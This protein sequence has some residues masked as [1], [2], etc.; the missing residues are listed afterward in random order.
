MILPAMVFVVL[1]WWPGAPPAAAAP[2]PVHLKAELL[3][4]AGTL[5]PGGTTWIGVRLIPDRGWHV[6]WTNPGDSG[7]P[8]V[9]SWKLPKGFTVGEVR[10]PRPERIPEGPLVSFGYTG[11]VLLMAPLMMPRDLSAGATVALAASARWL[12]CHEICIPGRAELSLSLVAGPGRAGASAGTFARA[13]G[14]L[15]APS[16]SGWQASAAVDDKAIVLDLVGADVRVPAYFFPLRENLLDNAAAQV[17]RRGKDGARL[18]LP[19]SDQA[20][21][22]SGP[23][24][25][26]LVEGDRAWAL[27]VPVGG[28]RAD[29]KATA[30]GLAETPAFLWALAF[31]F[32]GGMILNLM[33]CVFPILSIK[34]LGFVRESGHHPHEVRIH[35]LLYGTGVVVSF[36]AL[37]GTL[38]VL[39]S[40]GERLGW[41]FQLQSPVV[42]FLL[43][44]TLFLVALN[45]LGVFEAGT[46]VARHAGAVKWGEGR[47]AAFSTGVLATFLATPC[48]APFM[49]TAV[50]YAA[51]QPAAVGLGIFTALGL[52]MAA[53]YVALSFVPGLGRLLP[54][55]GRWMET[56]KQ[57]MAFPLIAT[58]IWMLWVLGLQAGLGAVT[59]SLGCLLALGIAGWLYGRWH[60]G[61][62]RAVAG[63]LIAL[64][65]AAV[66]AWLRHADPSAG[67]R[68]SGVWQPWSPARVE[69]ETAA[70]HPVLV[71]FTAAWCLTC[72]VNEAV[73]L[74]RAE[75]RTA[76]A[77]R[78]VV[79]LLADWPNPDPVIERALAGFGRN[80]VPLYVLY[81]GRRGEAPRLL[82]Q[83]L[84]P[85]LILDELTRLGP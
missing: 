48:T 70:G 81:S 60:T 19:L 69:R 64:A 58:V 41:G 52:G 42:I 39:K 34:V 75:V 38:L 46:T 61:K 33:P 79:M 82:P 20:K 40:G 51:V 47:I 50:G 31:A 12:V 28:G 54:R 67:E 7:T 55:P 18:T 78:G 56:F 68:A 76:L 77:R 36:W 63:A 14:A 53:P 23:L 65:L 85:K 26:I 1:A 35:G 17:L 21:S 6:Y 59:A 9:I 15:P 83:I 44:A 25:G 71:D 10:W 84:T 29:V 66:L 43:A 22:V 5:A 30:A 74:D 32:L 49:G 4:E 80:G 2:A 62:M 45:L 27:S 16:P 72:K 8:P 13:R 37:A 3:V 73:A 24:D 57:V 11:P